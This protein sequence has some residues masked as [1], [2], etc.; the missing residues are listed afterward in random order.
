[1]RETMLRA[2]RD[3]D[4]LPAALLRSVRSHL[5][6]WSLLLLTFLF[7]AGSIHAEEAEELELI[8]R[9]VNNSG[10]TGL[11]STTMP[12]TLPE[13]T[14]ETGLMLIS[15]NSFTPDYTIT[16]YP[17]AI[18]Y[19]TGRSSEVALR[20]V[21]LHTQ[22]S[23]LASSR[24]FGDTELSWKWNLRKQPESS[25]SPG[26]ALFFTGILPTGDREAGM[27]TVQ[28]WGMRAGLSAGSEVELADYIFGAYADGQ[29]AV[30]D[31]SDQ[32]YRD[33]Y[34]MLNLGMLFPISK[35]RNLQMIVEYNRMGGRDSTML[36]EVD[37]TAM[38]YGLRL[39][40]ER[41]NITIG[42]QLMRKSAE[43]YGNS[44]RI[45]GVISVKL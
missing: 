3:H 12:Q 30:Q 19:G 18:C 26:I 28:H 1:M 10:L 41:L 17:L 36:H 45:S 9:P 4:A 25:S 11:I 32:Q 29:I 24:G 31:L 13:G 44:S 6:V 16:S 15:E 22:E 42:T 39:V 43:E 7:L 40:S 20:A 33:R 38:A 23:D 37:Y 5:P 2:V 34:Q 27:N 35:Y 14:L 21:Y 8:N